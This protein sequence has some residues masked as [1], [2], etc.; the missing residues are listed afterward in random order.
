MVAI[1]V[2]F[3]AMPRILVTDGGQR[4][5]GACGVADDH[6]AV[7]RS[8]PRC[9][10]R[11]PRQGR[12]SPAAGRAAWRQTIVCGR[13]AR[14]R[15]R[16][17]AHPHLSRA[18]RR[19]DAVQTHRDHRRAPARNSKNRPVGSQIA[20]DHEP[21]GDAAWSPESPRAPRRSRSRRARPQLK[22]GR[23][24]GLFTAASKNERIAALQTHDLLSATGRASHQPIDELLLTCGRPR[25]RRRRAAFGAIEHRRIHQRVVRTRSASRAL[26]RLARQQIRVAWSRA[27]QRDDPRRAEEESWLDLVD[28]YVAATA[29]ARPSARPARARPGARRG[30]SIQRSDR[31]QHRSSASRVTREAPALHHPSRRHRVPARWTIAPIRARALVGD[32]VE[33]DV[34]GVGRLATAQLTQGRGDV[35]KPPGLERTPEDSVR[36]TSGQSRRPRPARNR[37]A[38]A[39]STVPELS[40]CRLVLHPPPARRPRA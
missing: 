27:D 18:A 23:H 9:F 34:P 37:D 32:G 16:C 22:P 11:D 12:S 14:H 19:V 26:R 2:P 13:C 1:F 3:T 8:G 6:R 5:P 39:A 20:H 25:S 15:R 24:P 7:D 36:A 28:R 21:G 4:R 33:E 10:D 31:R 38:S 17:D 30:R 40:R 29:A 35:P